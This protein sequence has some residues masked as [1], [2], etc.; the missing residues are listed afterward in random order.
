M[1][2]SDYYAQMIIGGG[3]SDSGGGGTPG[4]AA[5][6]QAGSTTTGEPGTQAQVTN[7]GTENAAVFDFVIPR[8]ADGAD[9]KDGAPGADG[10]DGAPGADGADGAAATI[11]VGQ[12]TT[13]EP[14][15]PAS[16][17]NVGTENAAIF[18]F[19][20][21][22]GEPGESGGG[23]GTPG[24]A[25]T[26]Q[27]GQVTTGEPGTDASVTNVGTENAA[28]FDF[29][30]PRG[31]DGAD[32]EDGAPGADGQD[33]QPGADG[34]GILW[35]TSEPTQDNP[36]YEIWTIGVIA[37]DNAISQTP[38][39]GDV[40][41]CTSDPSTGYYVYDYDD[42]YIYMNKKMT[43]G[44]S[45]GGSTGSDGM[46]LVSVPLDGMKSATGLQHALFSSSDFG[47][48]VSSGN[49]APGSFYPMNGTGQSALVYVPDSSHISSETMKVNTFPVNI[50]VRCEIESLDYAGAYGVLS[51]SGHW[52]HDD[53]SGKDVLNINFS[54]A[55]LTTDAD[56]SSTY[57][58][59]FLS[60]FSTTVE[61]EPA[62]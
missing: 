5:T 53:E 11:Q 27:V 2:H 17:T 56:G 4:K 10:A 54:P 31:A 30:I 9:G 3:G 21:P 6:I 45:G 12:V 55:W 60:N 46:V 43:L 51:G 22:K 40:V 34:R 38:Q 42:T 41:V 28:V 47:T 37:L 50:S 62:A 13:G 35:V 19:V 32:G 29:V 44:S 57:N 18:D 24:Q 52:T 36:E 59:V 48:P 58:V 7:S 14:G 25:A 20:I 49:G 15:T 39:A 1:K 61:I 26:I 23:G 16:V 33:G 8:G